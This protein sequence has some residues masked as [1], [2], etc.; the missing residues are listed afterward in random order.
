V[1]PS[2]KL[3]HQL[4]GGAS[5]VRYVAADRMLASEMMAWK[6]FPDSAP[7]SFFDLGCLAP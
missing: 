7:Q 3:D 6:Q 1:L 2:I 4:L 5:E